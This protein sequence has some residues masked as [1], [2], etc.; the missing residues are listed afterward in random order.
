M[1]SELVG[2]GLNILSQ[3]SRDGPVLQLSVA[4]YDASCSVLFDIRVKEEAFGG[5]GTYFSLVAVDENRAEALI[6]EN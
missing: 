1:M 6:Q 4:C 3:D 2:Q 5:G